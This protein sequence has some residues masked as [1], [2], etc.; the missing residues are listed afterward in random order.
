MSICYL[1]TACDIVQRKV[2]LFT[3]T[4]YRYKFVS[5]FPTIHF[6]CGLLS[7]SP[8]YG[9]FLQTNNF[10]L[11]K[12]EIGFRWQFNRRTRNEIDFWYFAFSCRLSKQGIDFHFR[13]ASDKKFIILLKIKNEKD[14]KIMKSLK[15]WKHPLPKDFPSCHEEW[16]TIIKQRKRGAEY[17][18]LPVHKCVHKFH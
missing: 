5:P 17:K 8:L 1:S 4:L 11:Y 9:H 14:F 18:K 12:Y 16:E 6:I 3:V 13:C 2:C 7:F 15:L 10:N